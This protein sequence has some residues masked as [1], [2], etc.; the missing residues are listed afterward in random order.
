MEVQKGERI[1]GRY[2]AGESL[3]LGDNGAVSIS[4]CTLEY[5][6]IVVDFKKSSFGIVDSILRNCTI[7]FKRKLK[8]DRLVSCDYINCKFIGKFEGVD[9][10]RSPWPNFGTNQMD[11]LGEIIE[12]DFTQAELDLCRFFSVDIRHQK[13]AQWPQFVVPRESALIASKLVKQWPGDFLRYINLLSGDDPAT[14]GAAG[15]AKDFMKR[16]RVTDHE[17][18]NA[19]D[20]IEGVIK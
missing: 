19:L 3:L 10:G 6:H 16:Y 5:C 8:N 2:M 14:T 20:E 9:F 15:S 11:L 4:K 13:F 12:C 7:E 1:D 18:L 17:L